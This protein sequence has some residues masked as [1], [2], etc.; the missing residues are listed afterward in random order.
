MSTLPDKAWSMPSIVLNGVTSRCPSPV[1]ANAVATA[2]TRPSVLTWS[3]RTISAGPE[4]LRDVSWWWRVEC[5]AGAALT[6]MAKTREKDAASKLNERADMNDLPSDG[7]GEDAARLWR[8]PLRLRQRRSVLGAAF[9]VSRKQTRACVH[10]ACAS[11]HA[12]AQ[13]LFA[14][15]MAL[16][17]ARARCQWHPTKAPTHPPICSWTN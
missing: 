1:S 2:S 12:P 4:V 10:V 11:P 14:P 9:A 13:A 8:N 5:L 15:S 6:A 3:P 17:C 7:V 16:T